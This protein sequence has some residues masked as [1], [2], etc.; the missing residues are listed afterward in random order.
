MI[1]VRWAASM[2][3]AAL[4]TLGLFYF[5]QFLIATGENLDEP[6]TVVKI[7]DSTMPEI[8][9]EVIEEIDKP[10][11]IEEVTEVVEEVERQIGKSKAVLRQSRIT[12]SFPRPCIFKNGQ[13][14]V[15]DL[16]MS[17]DISRSEQ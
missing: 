17:E 7:V 10:E 14:G 2:V 12:K 4:I 8:E 15:S 3:M 11:L 16:F 9:L 6:L 1:I 13:L 5:M